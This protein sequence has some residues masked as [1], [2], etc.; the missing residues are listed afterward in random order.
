MNS[1]GY[2]IKL[3]EW[4]GQPDVDECCSVAAAANE[5]VF[6]GNRA[7]GREI[8][9]GPLGKLEA[10]I[11]EEVVADGIHLGNWQ[12]PGP[13]HRD[14]LVRLL[15]LELRD[16]DLTVV[17]QRQG[18]RLLQSQRFDRPGIRLTGPCGGACL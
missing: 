8:A 15:G 14:P 1:E 3:R 11:A 12:V 5:S 9:K 17:L 4:L 2:A 7:G 18:N 16:P 6:G 13:R 10:N